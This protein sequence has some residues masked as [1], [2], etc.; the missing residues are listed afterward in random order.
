M[1]SRPG[2]LG[3]LRQQLLG[4]WER[5]AGAS[6]AVGVQVA[7]PSAE[8][9]PCSWRGPDAILRAHSQEDREVVPRLRRL[10]RSPAGLARVIP[11]S[12]LRGSL[13]KR[14]GP[15]AADSGGCRCLGGTA[16]GPGSTSS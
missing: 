11:S 12:W 4:S 7:P 16:A 9:A 3:A 5:A 8:A 15:R 1:V 2:R 14:H 6:Q 13:G 10:V